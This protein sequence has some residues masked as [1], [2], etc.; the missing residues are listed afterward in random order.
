MYHPQNM[1]EQFHSNET[2]VISFP[3]PSMYDIFCF[4]DEM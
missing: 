3:I 2:Q 4:L 1:L